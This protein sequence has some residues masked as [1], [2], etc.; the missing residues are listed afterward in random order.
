M[1]NLALQFLIGSSSF[2]QVTT[3]NKYNDRFEIQQDHPDTVGLAALICG[4]IFI[5]IAGYKDNHKILE[6]E[7]E[8]LPD[9]I[10]NC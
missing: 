5:T 10:S 2:Q 9:L 4:W 7:F 1:S 3:G 6:D 8:F